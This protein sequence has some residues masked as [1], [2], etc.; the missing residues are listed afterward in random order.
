MKN[1]FSILSLA[2]LVANAFIGHVVHAADS[3]AVQKVKGTLKISAQDYKKVKGSNP[4]CA[5]LLSLSYEESTDNVVVRLGEKFIFPKLNKPQFTE[6]GDEGCTVATTT[7]LK[8]GYV[9][10][11]WKQSCKSAKENYEAQ[12]TLSLNEGRLTF[13]YQKI[14]NKKILSKYE[15]IY[16]AGSERKTQ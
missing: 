13:S 12:Q 6:E 5:G 1:H 7:S 16:S 9:H 14:S 2:I 8:E 3:A 11:D 15:C 4:Q 10:Q